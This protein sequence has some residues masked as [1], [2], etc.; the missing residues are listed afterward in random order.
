MKNYKVELIRNKLPKNYEYDFEL[1]DD[2][3]ENE[4]ILKLQEELGEYLNKKHI[5]NLVEIY[6]IFDELLYLRTFSIKE[7]KEKLKEVKEIKG[8]Y[9]KR[10]FDINI[11]DG[12]ERNFNR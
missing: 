10:S 1:D 3:Y 7:I 8:S 5:H 4:L 6:D 11:G 9:S 2:Y 12:D